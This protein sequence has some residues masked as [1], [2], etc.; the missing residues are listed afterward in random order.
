MIRNQ[1]T[2]GQFL[3]EGK[4]LQFSAGLSPA[5]F[6][7]LPGIGPLARIRHSISPIISYFFAPAARVDSAYSI[8][9][10]PTDTL[11]NAR[12]DPQQTISIGLSQNF[13]G[14]LR[15]PPHDTGQQQP[16]KLRLLSIN[17][18]P[19]S[20]NFERAKQPGQ[21]GWQTQT[22]GN[23]FA[24]DLLPNFSLRLV[25][26][27]WDGPV[28]RDSSKFA[29]FLTSVNASFAISPSTVRGFAHLLGFHTGAGPAAAPAPAP[30]APVPP[31]G[32]MPLPTPPLFS[33]PTSSLGAGAGGAGA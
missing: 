11:L 26:D 5:F 7:F 23:T 25:H 16:R 22:V 3:R 24:S 27:L 9:L 19:I 32:S 8:A 10:D 18:D 1:F 30:A 29:P 28:G 17:T 21:T 15:P 31:V 12:S 14:K 20:Y 4:R 13:E 33:G 2:N 6:G